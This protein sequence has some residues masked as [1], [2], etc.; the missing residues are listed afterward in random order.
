MTLTVLTV[1]LAL[2]P[3]AVGGDPAPSATERKFVGLLNQERAAQG[4]TAVEISPALTDVADDYVA[5]N[6]EQG[7]FSHDRD[8]PFTARANQA[9]CGK[10]S[11][12]VLAQGYAGPAEVLQG[13]L[14]SPGHRAVLLDPENTHI[15]AGFKGEHALAY[16][17]PCTPEQNSSGDFGDPEAREPVPPYEPV[18]PEELF[19]PEEWFPSTEPPTVNPEGQFLLSFGRSG[20]RGR[21]IFTRV[22]VRAG[23]GRL[24]LVARSG[25]RVV[26]GQPV[27]ATKRMRPYRPAVRVS[28]LGRW[29]VSLRVNGRP[30][31]R[32]TVRLGPR[33]EM[34]GHAARTPTGWRS[35]S[36]RTAP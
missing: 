33:G 25:A 15:G 35:N 26:R 12:P 10:W 16:V 19:P 34:R 1:T 31:R 22:R 2:P 7:G 11:G 28:R 17:M 5:Q 27:A 8:P 24:R 30:A 29:R 18:P 20:I 9:G 4:M 32:F 3:V 14:N 6:S 13:W 23:R 36:R 21:T